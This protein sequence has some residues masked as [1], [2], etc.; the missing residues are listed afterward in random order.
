MINVNFSLPP[1]IS[2]MVI[3]FLDSTL[4]MR[5]STISKGRVGI[6]RIIPFNQSL[7]YII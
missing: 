5:E 4:H 7:S 2:M 1:L 3:L 6:G